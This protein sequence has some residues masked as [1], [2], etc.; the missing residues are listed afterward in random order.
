V[1]TDKTIPTTERDLIPFSVEEVNT[2]CPVSY[3]VM[4]RCS[5]YAS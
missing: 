1:E 3:L 2:P 5:K 4:S